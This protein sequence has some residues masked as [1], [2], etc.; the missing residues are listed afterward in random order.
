MFYVKL[1]RQAKPLSFSRNLSSSLLWAQ[2]ASLKNIFGKCTS[3][4]DHIKTTNIPHYSGGMGIVHSYGDSSIRGINNPFRY[5]KSIQSSYFVC[6]IDNMFMNRS[7]VWDGG[8]PFYP[9][10]GID[11]LL[12]QYYPYVDMD[13]YN[14]RLSTIKDLNRVR[15]PRYTKGLS[16]YN[17]FKTLFTATPKITLTRGSRGKAPAICLRRNKEYLRTY[18]PNC[19]RSCDNTSNIA[20]RHWVINYVVSNLMRT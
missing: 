12:S 20:R 16:V 15:R 19:S 11:R 9:K 18:I 2:Q 6:I 13:I 10:Y 1:R 14:S 8:Q 5:R 3:Y 7:S 17:I 4:C